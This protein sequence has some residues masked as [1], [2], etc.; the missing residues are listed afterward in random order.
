MTVFRAAV[1]EFPA[2]NLECLPV[3]RPL[4]NYSALGVSVQRV[5]EF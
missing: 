5:I 1:D 4:G 3:K 2:G